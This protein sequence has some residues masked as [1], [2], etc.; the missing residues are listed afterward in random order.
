VAD[1]DALRY[2]IG[3]FV[4]VA[5]PLDRATR[6]AHLTTLEQAPARFRA[7]AAGLSDGQLDTPYRVGGWT[8]RQV[9]HHVPDSH[10][11]AYIRTKLA[12]TE[13]NPRITTYEEQIWAELPEAKRGPIDVSLTLLDA[14]HRRWLAFLRGLSESDFARTFQHKEW[15]GVT[16]DEAVAM[17]AWHSKH[18]AAHIE[19]ALKGASV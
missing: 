11:N 8:V 15:G 5:T 17:Y 14:L 16:I 3:K 13:D 1:L 7:L 18:H 6:D 9:I 12:A 19:Q 2:P 4:R 10:L